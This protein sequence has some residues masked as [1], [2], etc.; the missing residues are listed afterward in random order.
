MNAG[1]SDDTRQMAAF[2]SALGIKKMQWAADEMD[3]ATAG[4]KQSWLGNLAQGLLDP[5]K[6]FHT[7][8]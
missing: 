8:G 2:D 4:D 6:Y 7:F 5:G 1:R 3:D